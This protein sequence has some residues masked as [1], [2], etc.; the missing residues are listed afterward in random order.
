VDIEPP[1]DTDELTGDQLARLGLPA[2]HVHYRA[3][4][5]PAETEGLSGEQPARLGQPAHHVHYRAGQP[6]G[7]ELLAPEDIQVSYTLKD[8]EEEQLQQVQEKSGPHTD[9]RPYMKRRRPQQHSFP[10]RIYN[11]EMAIIDPP[12]AL[13]AM[14]V[15][16]SAFNNNG[17]SAVEA[18][19][20]AAA[21]ETS[22]LRQS[23]EDERITPTT[24]T[25]ADHDVVATTRV[26]VEDDGEA[27]TDAIFG[28]PAFCGL[29]CG[30]AGRCHLD[31]DETGR[32][33][34]RCLC[35]LGWSGAGC[36]EP[37]RG[38]GVAELTGLSYLAFPTLQNAYSDL[39]LSLDFRP[40]SWTGKEHNV[41]ICIFFASI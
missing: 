10:E 1:A 32:A 14:E 20:E 37:V 29:E 11:E 6:A 13:P 22:E 9:S 30:P 41:N 33:A 25:I 21:T 19:V 34:Q 35:S 16:A 12:R 36:A 5:Q 39:H 27:L 17:A 23:E 28:V 26:A 3:G 2:H 24:A 40:T 15:A 38:A 8:E 4:G 18:E 7:S 31:R